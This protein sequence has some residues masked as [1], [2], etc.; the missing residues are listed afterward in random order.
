MDALTGSEG[1]FE[2]F[3]SE[4]DDAIV[5]YWKDE[6]VLQQQNAMVEL[7]RKR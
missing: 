3:I 6:A 4:R 2:R 7:F 1:R 5:T